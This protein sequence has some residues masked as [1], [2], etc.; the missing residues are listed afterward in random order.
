MRS[1]NVRGAIVD[2][3]LFRDRNFSSACLMM[4]FMGVGFFGS[5]VL[6]PQMIQQVFGYPPATTGVVLFPRVAIGFLIMPFLGATLIPR[7]DIRWLI[8]FGI[9]SS[10]YGCYL[11]SRYSINM[12]PVEL[13]VPGLVQGIGMSFLFVP[14][15]TVAYDTLDPR[16]SASA[17]GLYNL[18]RIL[19]GSIG[20]AVSESLLTRRSQAHWHT[21]G[22]HLTNTGSALNA[23][24]DKFGDTAL[25]GIN[26]QLSRQALMLAF[27]DLFWLIALSYLLLLPFLLLAKPQPRS[28]RAAGPRSAHPVEI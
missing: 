6:W 2:L 20:I 19:G 10:A 8:L 13:L 24:R 12:G 18:V 26:L 15:S 7:I 4:L 1:W 25:A 17:S 3:T 11:M 5:I 22:A 14:I 27:L 16:R 9:L 23:A 21:L 28:W